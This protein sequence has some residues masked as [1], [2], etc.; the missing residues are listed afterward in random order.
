MKCPICKSKVFFHPDHAQCENG[1]AFSMQQG[2]YQIA[3]PEYQER[4]FT[5]LKHF[6]DSRSDVTARY[7]PEILRKLPEAAFDQDMWNLR[8]M[9]LK[10]VLE[11]IQPGYKN[12]LEIGAWNGWLTHHLARHGLNTTAVDIFLHD[13]DGLSA[14]QHYDEDWRA[15]QMDLQ[16]LDL[17]AEQFDLIVVNRSIPYFTDIV[18]TFEILKSLLAPGGM[19]IITGMV[20]TRNP[21]RIERALAT[22]QKTFEERYDSPFYLHEYR[23]YLEQ[24]D[25]TQLQK[26]GLQLHIYPQLRLQ[27]FVGKFVASRPIHYYGTFSSTR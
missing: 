1:H 18:R 26:S 27:S 11:H 24:N 4:L 10:L 9:D 13:R 21:E 7:T 17:L 15:V 25:L 12:A 16:R 20:Y 3:T 5:F 19:L 6:E 14:K 2:V 8:K 23:G 22:A